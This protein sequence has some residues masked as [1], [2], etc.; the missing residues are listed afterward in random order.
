VPVAAATSSFPPIRRFKLWQFV[1]LV[2]LCVVGIIK[3]IY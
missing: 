2:F 1:P 3:L